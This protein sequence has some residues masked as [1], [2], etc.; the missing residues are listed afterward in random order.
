VGNYEELN[1]CKNTTGKAEDND[2]QSIDGIVSKVFTSLLNQR[3]RILA[4]L[5]C[6]TTSPLQWRWMRLACA[7]LLLACVLLGALSSS[8]EATAATYKAASFVLRNET[9][10]ST[11][12][13]T[14][15]L[16]G[17]PSLRPSNVIALTVPSA[18]SASSPLTCKAS[19]NSPS[20]ALAYYELTATLQAVQ[21]ATPDR[22]TLELSFKRN[23]QLSSGNGSEPD[24][25]PC[26]VVRIFCDSL[27]IPVAAGVSPLSVAA[28]TSSPITNSQ[29]AALI[30]HFSALTAPSLSNTVQ[31]RTLTQHV[32]TVTKMPGLLT[33]SQ[34]LLLRNAVAARAGISTAAV[35]IRSQAIVEAPTPDSMTSSTPAAAVSASVPRALS[36]SALEDGVTPAPAATF[37]LSVAV[38]SG[39]E[40]ADDAAEYAVLVRSPVGLAA[41]SANAQ[42]EL[43]DSLTPDEDIGAGDNGDGGGL[44]SLSPLTSSV[45]SPLFTAMAA[46]G[47]TVT[48]EGAADVTFLAHCYN[49]ARDSDE[50]DTDCGGSCIGCGAAKACSTGADCST[51]ICTPS[52]N[53]CVY[54]TSA[55]TAVA[56][57]LVFAAAA[58]S[59]LTLAF[60]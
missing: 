5:N 30:T 47:V 54:S 21:P 1:Q 34:M 53:V 38:V 19:L 11:T 45:L 26:T 8:S 43:V 35:V 4:V 36:F 32:V 15:R 18:W 51:G 29:S 42:A 28:Y 33:A 49:G 3:K 60:L 25:P 40:T 57:G 10:G 59:A 13:T 27:T 7:T 37:T 9:R 12:G 20:E 24:A 6:E 44:T 56:P 39:P 46:G 14:L 41:L 23:V 55:A 17:L 58:L 16:C 50:S 2:R 48:F 52:V 22:R 31:P